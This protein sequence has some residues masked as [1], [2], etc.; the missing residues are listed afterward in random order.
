MKLFSSLNDLLCSSETSNSEHPFALICRQK[1]TVVPY[2]FHKVRCKGGYLI[3]HEHGT[4]T[5]DSAAP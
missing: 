4:V 5:S 3:L 2:K 1:T